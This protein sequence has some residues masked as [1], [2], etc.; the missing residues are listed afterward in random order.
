MIDIDEAV[1]RLQ[2]EIIAP[3]WRLN[4]KRIGG[5][6]EA[7]AAMRQ[8]LSARREAASVVVMAE[9]VLKHIAGR[10]GRVPHELTGFLKE[11]MAHTVSLYEAGGDDSVQ[12]AAVFQRAYKRFQIV[13]GRVQGKIGKSSS[14]PA[15]GGTDAENPLPQDN[16]SSLPQSEAGE[17]GGA[18]DLQSGSAA[19]GESEHIE[20][21][22][23]GAA[24]DSF[25]LLQGL[26]HDLHKLAV[27]VDE[28]GALLQR[29]WQHVQAM[30]LPPGGS[31]AEPGEDGAAAAGPLGELNQGRRGVHG[32]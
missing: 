27:K 9:N 19:S 10:Q 17:A 31:W 4:D 32:K 7:L 20:K 12:D 21:S 2:A 13:K 1:R 22:G 11:A 8:E 25:E 6:R 26:E 28:Q 14:A 23:A 30:G 5:L 18:G 16:E 24:A 29:I 15:V 3:D